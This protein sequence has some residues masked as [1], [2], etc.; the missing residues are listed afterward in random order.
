MALI[1]K[2]TELRGQGSVHR[3]ETDAGWATVMNG[4]ETLL[5]I[6]TYGSDDRASRPKTSQVIQ[7][8]QARA[9]ELLG[10]IQ[11]VFPGIKPHET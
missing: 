6:G 2:F 10:I 9:A 3:S 1:R 8:D 7:L 5:Y 4:A 11:E